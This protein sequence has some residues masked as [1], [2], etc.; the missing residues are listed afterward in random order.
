MSLRSLSWVPELERAG[1]VWLN[2]AAR[3][4]YPRLF[5]RA[6]SR[7]GNGVIWYAIMA[8]LPVIHGIA[9]FGLALRMLLAALVGLILYRLLK[10]G[11]SRPR[12]YVTWPDI[13][14]A[15]LPLD[16]YSFPSGHTL[17]AVSFSMLLVAGS[18][19]WAWFA[20]PFTVLVALSRPILGL[21]YPGDVLA[22]AAI[23][24]AV[25]GTV[26]MLLPLP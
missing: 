12:P 9:G 15:A 19:A 13:T 21:H 6:V 2:G 10:R 22:G 7:L 26:L 25:A 5:F 11:T 14:P 20:V 1:L 4:R 16:Q 3:Y 18:P 24:A 8:A 23:G 17:H